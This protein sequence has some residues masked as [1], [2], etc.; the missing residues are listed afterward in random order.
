MLRTERKHPYYAA[1]DSEGLRMLRR[2]LITISVYD[3]ELS[4]VQGMNEIVAPILL[5]L[6]VRNFLDFSA[7]PLIRFPQDESL[8]FWCF[9]KLLP[10]LRDR[11]L[12]LDISPQLSSTADLLQHFDV[13][14]YNHIERI[15]C[16]HWLFCFRFA[17]ET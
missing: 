13:E 1:E 6:K 3:T 5:N 9:V 7:V 14:L 11:L 4:Y 15:T 2:I 17:S 10:I 12:T 8:T 16:G